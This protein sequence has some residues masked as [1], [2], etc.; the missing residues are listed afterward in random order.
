MDIST[1]MQLAAHDTSDSDDDNIVW[2]G[3]Y[4]LWPI[5]ALGPISELAILRTISH[6]PWW[7]GVGLPLADCKHSFG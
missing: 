1:D 3:C 7:V 6:Q 5:L 4:C 2:W